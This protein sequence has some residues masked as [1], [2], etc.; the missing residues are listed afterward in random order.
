L[1]PSAVNSIRFLVANASKALQAN[2]V[3]VVDN[4]GNVLSENQENDPLPASQQQLSARRNLEAIPGQE[5]R[6]MLERALGPGQAIVRVAAEINWD[7]I[8]RTGRKF[9][10]TARLREHDN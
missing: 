9:Y 10:Q 8:T 1:P 3:P 4:L 7:T 5:S 6:S 2:S